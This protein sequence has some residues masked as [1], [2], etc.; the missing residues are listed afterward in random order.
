MTQADRQLPILHFSF[1]TPL[2]VVS[3]F[4]GNIFCLLPI[5]L[6]DSS[7][8]YRI[9][10]YPQRERWSNS[11][12]IFCV[13]R[14]VSRKVASSAMLDSVKGVIGTNPSPSGCGDG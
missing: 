11:M 9:C 4:I 7:E 10:F 2:L 8:A 1:V 6:I 5:E 3:F 12:N 14:E 13:P